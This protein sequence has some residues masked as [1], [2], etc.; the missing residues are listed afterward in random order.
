MA[1]ISGI[2]QDAGQLIAN[3][4]FHV[5]DDGLE[6]VPIVGVARQCHGVQ[7]KLAALGAVQCRGHRDLD[8]KLV[9]FVCFSLADAL[10]FVGVQAVDLATALTLLLLQNGFCLI[11]R[12][13]EDCLELLV[14]GDLTL[15]IAHDASQIRLQLAQRLAGALELLGMGI[16]LM[17]DKRILAEPH[18]GDW[19][20]LSPAFL[21]ARTSRSRA[22]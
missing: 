12:P 2:S 17:L 7:G 19:R 10:N 21:A 22:R 5:G 11:E 3:G 20:R 13:D 4:L 6:S 16:A 18:V 15:D 8:A 14:A 9:W 1:A